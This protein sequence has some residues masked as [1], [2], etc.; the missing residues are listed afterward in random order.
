[1]SVKY[2]PKI[3]TD[4]LTICCDAANIRSY[5][6]S[7]TT[8]ADLSGYGSDA[9]LVSDPTYETSNLGNFYF[10]T[11]SYADIGNINQYLPSGNQSHNF[12]I[13]MWVK[14]SNATTTNQIF[15][16]ILNNNDRLYLGKANGY[17]QFGWGALH[18][19]SGYTGTQSI[20]TTEWTNYVF[21][22]TNGVAVLFINSIETISRTDTSVNL[23][24]TFP[25]GSY[26]N[27]NILHSATAVANN[28]SS[29]KI[30]NRPLS[31]LEISQNF[32]ATRGRFGI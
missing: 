26:F 17:W 10:N 28:I 13:D 24:S 3:I 4:S 8:W 11:S 20:V 32:N 15:T 16:G 5:P 18:W 29:F 31:L 9:T 14:V 7:G 21:R 2:N 12:T 25:V 6:G 19:N 30:Y 1:M 22:V 23:D 27:G